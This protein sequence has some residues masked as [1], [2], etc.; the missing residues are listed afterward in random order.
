MPN[1]KRPA[2]HPRHALLI[3]HLREYLAEV[4]KSARWLG[5]VT[6]RDPRLVPGLIRGQE[7]P[8]AVMLKLSERLLDFYTAQLAADEA[9]DLP[10]AA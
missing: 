1:T 3:E 8:T 10:L 9:A 2:P 5:M 7:Y 6:A 4:G